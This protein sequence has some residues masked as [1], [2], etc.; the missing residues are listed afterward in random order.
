MTDGGVAIIGDLKGKGAYFIQGVYDYISDKQERGFPVELIDIE[1]TTFKDNEF[2]VRIKENVRGRSCVF[3]HDPNQEPA[4]WFTK[5]AF[6]TDALKFSASKE[7]ITVLPYMHY[8]RQDRKDE[9]RVGVS[10]KVVADITSLYST[11]G[12]TVDLHAPQIQEYFSIPFDNLYS[13]PTLVKHL[14]T[15][16]PEML[17]KLIIATPDTGGG[18]RAESLRKRLKNVGVDTGMAFGYKK[19]NTKGKVESVQL[20]GD[21]KDRH[22]LFVDDIIATGDT[23]VEAAKEA[24]KQGAKSVSAYATQGIFTAGTAKLKE[25]FDEI[26]V[27]DTIA[28]TDTNIETVSLIPLFGEAIYR[29]LT[30]QS[31]SELFV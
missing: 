1:T 17:E 26:M 4:M 25:V 18:G 28:Q 7:R 6:I 10:A 15:N 9:S 20:V 31:L 8:Q 2:K 27:G 22:L 13:F 5:L 24:R 3:I 12:M 21:I 29:Q 23:L 16:H 11:R 19:R 30:N 14:K